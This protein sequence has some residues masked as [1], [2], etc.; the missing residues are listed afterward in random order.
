MRVVDSK[1]FGER[2][3]SCRRKD[4]QLNGNG[5]CFAIQQEVILKNGTRH[6]LDLEQCP[7]YKKR[8]ESK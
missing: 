4:C 8:V 7:F 5:Q 1:V 6:H 2:I 3:T